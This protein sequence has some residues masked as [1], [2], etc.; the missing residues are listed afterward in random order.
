MGIMSRGGICLPVT[1]VRYTP[2]V[3]N[4]KCP[5]IFTG[6]N[7]EIDEAI[8]KV[9]LWNTWI[10]ITSRPSDDLDKL[11]QYIDFE[12]M[13]LGFTEENVLNYAIKFLQ[14]PEHAKKLVAKAKQ[15]NM[16]DVLKIPIMLQMVCEL[17]A[18]RKDLPQTKIEIMESIFRSSFKMA[19]KLSGA[20]WSEDEVREIMYKLG[21]LSWQSLQKDT[22]Q[23]L[24]NKV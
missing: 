17:Y 20:T 12:A 3:C 18:S 16:F 8:R 19:M 14:N 15:K 1:P 13:I 22:N 4:V 10:I 11:K 7:T 21:K 6:S 23:L 2:L 5:N 24:L 9:S